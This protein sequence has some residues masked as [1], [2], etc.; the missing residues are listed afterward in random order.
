MTA[1]D[2]SVHFVDHPLVQHKLTLMRKK[3]TSTNSFRR[4]LGELSSLMAY[5]VTREMPMHEVEIETPIAKMTSKL[6]DGKKI[7][8]VPILRAGL[9]ILD[10]MLNVVPGARI[11]H[12]GLYRDPKTLT[13]VEYYFKMPHGMKERDVIV[14]D[15]MLA[16]GNSAIAAVER[17]KESKPKSIRFVCLLTCPEGIRNFHAVHPDVP[18]Y[19]AAIDQGLNDHGY[20]VPGLGDAGD[21]IFGT[22]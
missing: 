6:I 4:L 14:V 11:G 10:G 3:E 19:T 17:L 15:P 20:I 21:R 1:S 9:G 5:E 12:I 7:V 18:I 8:F 2:S 16:T 13:A 22:K